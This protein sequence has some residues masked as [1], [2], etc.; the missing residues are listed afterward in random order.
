MTEIP[1]LFFRRPDMRRAA[2]SA[3]DCGLVPGSAMPVSAFVILQSPF[4]Q[5]AYGFAS[6]LSSPRPVGMSRVRLTSSPGYPWLRLVTLGDRL[7]D[8]RYG[9]ASPWASPE[10]AHVGGI[11]DSQ[12]AGTKVP[13]EIG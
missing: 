5:L 10:G 12:P 4:L 8:G 3:G 1:R 7:L 2:R 13:P 9:P 11:F 6:L